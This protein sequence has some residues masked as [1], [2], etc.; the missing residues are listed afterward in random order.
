MG[1]DD[2]LKA[3]LMIVVAQHGSVSLFIEGDMSTTKIMSRGVVMAMA[4][5]ETLKPVWLRMRPNVNGT[6]PACVASRR[7]VTRTELPG[8]AAGVNTPSD[9]DHV[10]NWTSTHED[11][12]GVP[13]IAL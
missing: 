12:I 2:V 9:V 10:P 1:G 11:V 8:V 13:S 6:G 7:I 4:D 3:L 5:R